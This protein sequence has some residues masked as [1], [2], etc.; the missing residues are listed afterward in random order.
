MFIYE[1]DLFE[2]EG[3]SYA[4]RR[5][6]HE[7]S[8]RGRDEMLIFGDVQVPLTETESLLEDMLVSSL[9]R[10]P[11]L[12]P[13]ERQANSIYPHVWELMDLK[14]DQRRRAVRKL[15]FRNLSLADLLLDE[16]SKALSKH[17]KDAVEFAES[18][19]WIAG[20]PWPEEP[21][22]AA[23]IR[24]RAWIAQADGLREARDWAGAEL[25]FGAAFS[26]LG[27]IPPGLG[28]DHTSFCRRLSKL[29]EDQGRLYEAAVL[30][31][32]AMHLHCKSF[33]AKELPAD[34]LVHLAFLSLRQ[35][36]LSSAMSLLTSLCERD[37]ITYWSELDADFGRVICL[38]ASGLAE[39]ARKLLNQTLPKRHRI[40]ERKRR[41]PYE[42]LECRI[43]VHLGDLDRAIPRLEAI[44]RWLFHYDE[45]APITL[46]SIDLA[47]A[48]AKNGNAAQRLPGLL[49]DL[50]DEPGAR[51]WALGALTWFR[52]ALE[53]G[54]DPD[55]AARQAAEIVHRR[56]K[57]ATPH[58]PSK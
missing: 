53:Q 23:S 36:D 15:P 48:Y 29:R 51:L 14:P 11:L 13:M 50:A 34:G 21:G 17:P 24:A 10:I 33:G 43:S 57:S 55:L 8:P 3:L 9:R 41:L 4:E 7:D 30:Y 20:L 38:A 25:R 28:T 47:L 49:N 45:L 52:D 6:R 1:E 44:R 40:D 16:S 56:G 22:R 31:L 19:E 46:C 27:E 35:N 42:W 26:I 2:E 58:A 32:N 12:E 18:A 39:L 37:R 5:Q 54:Q